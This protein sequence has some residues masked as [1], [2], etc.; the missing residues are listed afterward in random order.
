MPSKINLN[1][2]VAQCLKFLKKIVEVLIA[3]SLRESSFFHVTWKQLM[4]AHFKNQY[5]QIVNLFL[6]FS[7]KIIH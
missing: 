3:R 4:K 5:F 1:I 7:K 6:V 2:A